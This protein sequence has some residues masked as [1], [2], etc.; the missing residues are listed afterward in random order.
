MVGLAIVRYV[1]CLTLGRDYPKGNLRYI[2]GRSYVEI[3]VDMRY[4]ILRNHLI[5][6]SNPA[7]PQANQRSDFA[8]VESIMNSQARAANTRRT[9]S[10]TKADKQYIPKNSTYVEISPGEL[11][12]R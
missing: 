7:H 9:R 2:N 1:S 12:Y 8:I 11:I 3:P 10:R 6:Y 4:L 5:N